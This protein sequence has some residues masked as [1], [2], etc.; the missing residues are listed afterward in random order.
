MAMTPFDVVMS[1]APTLTDDQKRKVIELIGG[2]DVCKA[3]GHKFKM[4]ETKSDIWYEGRRTYMVCER[5][6][7]KEKV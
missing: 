2:G 4:I 6:G 1:I 7:K 5:C 3:N